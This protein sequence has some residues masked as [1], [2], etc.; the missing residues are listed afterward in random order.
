MCDCEDA[1]Y[2]L[3]RTLEKSLDG[4]NEQLNSLVWLIGRLDQSIKELQRLHNI[5]DFCESEHPMLK[6][7]FQQHQFA[8]GLVLGDDD[9]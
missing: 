6:K 5:E 3:E 9:E 1:I 2:S 7:T 8:K 4:T